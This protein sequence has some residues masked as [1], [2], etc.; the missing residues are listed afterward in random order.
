MDA[1]QPRA[2]DGAARFSPSIGISTE[3]AA[4]SFAQVIDVACASAHR[5]IPSWCD[6]R[7]MRL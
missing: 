4:S 5:K 6:Y 3:R 7:T 2:H 1:E